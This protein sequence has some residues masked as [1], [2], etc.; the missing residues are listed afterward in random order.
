M[1]GYVESEYI[2]NKFKYI[3]HV[4]F[5]LLNCYWKEVNIRANQVALNGAHCHRTVM[6][7]ILNR[8]TMNHTSRATYQ[9]TEL[10]L[11]DTTDPDG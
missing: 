9:Q 1:S 11:D 8:L 7:S 4:C 3:L 6:Y 5:R 2:Q 10:I